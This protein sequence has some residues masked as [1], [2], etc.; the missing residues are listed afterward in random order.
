MFS[1]RHIQYK[2]RKSNP[3]VHLKNDIW[4]ALPDDQPQSL[5]TLLAVDSPFNNEQANIVLE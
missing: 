2:M 1:H 5:Q 3:I 4:Y